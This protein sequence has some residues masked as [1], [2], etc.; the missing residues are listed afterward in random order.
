M[1]KQAITEAVQK[2]EKTLGFMC[3]LAAGMFGY[4]LTHYVVFWG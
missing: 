4:Y 1:K 3:F 2:H